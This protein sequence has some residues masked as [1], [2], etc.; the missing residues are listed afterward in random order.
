MRASA[1]THHRLGGRNVPVKDIDWR[2]LGSCRG[3][4][5]AIFYPET[6]EEAD[7]AKIVCAG[8][9]VRTACLEHA[10]QRR[11]KQG[12]WGGSTERERRRIIRQR[13]RSA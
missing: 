9:G 3:L 5:P 4:D 6:E 12:V 13:R 1:I 2:Q 11:E 7:S 8:C 10:L